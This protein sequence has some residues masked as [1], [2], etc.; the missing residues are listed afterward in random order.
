[1]TQMP[2]RRQAQTQ[3]SRLG[4][5][6]TLSHP[7]VGVLIHAI[8]R[9]EFSRP[10]ISVMLL[11][12]DLAQYGQADPLSDVTQTLLNALIGAR[13]QAAEWNES[14]AHRGLLTFIG[15]FLEAIT[16]DPENPPR[17]FPELCDALLADGYE[18]R[19]EGKAARHVQTG[20]TR[21]LM[22]SDLRFELLPTDAAPVPLAAE[23]SAL[24]AELTARG[25]TSTLNHYQQ[26]VA[27]FGQHNFEAANSQ[28][29]TTLEDL[30]VHIAEEHT[31]FVKPANAGGGGQ[32]VQRLKVT[33]SL[34]D[35]DGGG[36]L[37]ALWRMS[38]TKG[39]HPGRSDADETR[40][41]MQ[42][43]TATSRLILHRFPR[44]FAA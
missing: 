43:I 41:R 13:E 22:A 20:S 18:L 36:L 42:V 6:Q 4:G 34:A 11:R 24:Q 17:W 10:E 21:F 1:M 8:T 9:H 26:A 29:R 27:A 39:S 23:I 7:T 25:Y 40:F 5:M 31:N 30:V 38:H 35:N 44:Q 28:L 14:K 12:S 15:L 16:I 3:A 37:E 33:E 32:A 2:S 19:W